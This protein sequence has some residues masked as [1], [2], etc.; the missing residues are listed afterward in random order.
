M[1]FQQQTAMVG[2]NSG[3]V[4]NLLLDLFPVGAGSGYSVRKLRTGYSGACLRVRRS[5]D[6]TEQ[7]IGFTSAGALDTSAISSFVG[8]NSGFVVTWYDQGGNG[9][10]VTQS[11]TGR[12]PR[13]V[14][15]G[16]IDTENS[17][18]T[19]VFDGSDDALFS[20]F[21]SSVTVSTRRFT[22]AAVVR[23]LRTSSSSEAFVATKRSGMPDYDSGFKL[24]RTTTFIDVALNTGANAGNNLGR[25]T[26][27][28]NT[29]ALTQVHYFI[30]PQTPS[31]AM[32]IDGTAK[33]LTTFYTNG[34]GSIAN[35][36]NAGAGSHRIYL[37]ASGEVPTDTTFARWFQGKISEVIL[38]PEDWTASRATMALNQKTY[39]GTP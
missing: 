35:H 19:V 1:I 13:I 32:Y 7:D 27:D 11:T 21:S 20:G 37:G 39:F 31:D 5:S 12:Q 24:G 8:A 6:N 18:P 10:N 26:S 9:I 17:L 25:E 29:S 4:G 15:A 22:A 16:A 23:S 2:L 36:Q 38:W 28:T 14:N 30:T 33:T 34:T 3:S